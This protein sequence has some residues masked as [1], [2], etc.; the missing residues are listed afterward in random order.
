MNQSEI[1]FRPTEQNSER[2]EYTK[3]YLTGPGRY[4]AFSASI[5]L[6]V[7]QEDGAW[8]PVI[9]AF[10]AEKDS[11]G[12]VSHGSRFTAVCSDSGPA[13]RITVTDFRGHS[14]SWETEGAAPV[15]A[16]IPEPK[17]PETKDP[18]EALFL[19]AP[20]LLYH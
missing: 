11:S 12:Y 10:Q 17:K 4:H 16:V 13:P 14:L 3:S 15:K 1:R 20:L 7:Q 8:T 2:G 5:P 9:A 6:H 18:A 19:E